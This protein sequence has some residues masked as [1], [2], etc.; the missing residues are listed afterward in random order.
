MSFSRAWC[1]SSSPIDSSL[2]SRTRRL[3][4]LQG[5]VM[6]KIPDHLCSVYVLGHTTGHRLAPRILFARA[7]PRMAAPHDAHQGDR[8]PVATALIAL[9]LDRRAVVGLVRQILVVGLGLTPVVLLPER[10]GVRHRDHRS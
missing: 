4:G 7:G 3:A 1:S 2:R 6:E 5:V 9:D 10:H 8:A